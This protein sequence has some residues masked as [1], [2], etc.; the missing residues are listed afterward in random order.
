MKDGAGGMIIEQPLNTVEQARFKELEQIISDNFRAFVAVG[1]ALAEISK[2]ELYRDGSGRTFEA[3][4]RENW[5]VSRSRAYQL[6]GSAEVMDNLS[7]IVDKSEL[8]S[9]ES[10]ARIMIGMNPVAQQAVW[11]DVIRWADGGKT[12]ARLVK[13]AVDRTKDKEIDKK[14][15]KSGTGIKAKDTPESAAFMVAWDVLWELVGGERKTGWKNISKKILHSKLA[16]LTDLVVDANG[17]G[18]IAASMRLSD[19]EKLHAAGF[20]LVRMSAKDL[21]LSEWSGID[22]WL[23]MESYENHT[24][25]I[26]A[27]NQLLEDKKTLRA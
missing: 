9:N 4:C 7:T 12:T 8:P 13:V 10:Q 18:K 17:Q 11:A 14:I 20:R 22:E 23:H 26:E 3:Y 1:Q 24:S 15:K 6:I 25:L 21:T 27:F 16:E 19:R 5:D 2:N